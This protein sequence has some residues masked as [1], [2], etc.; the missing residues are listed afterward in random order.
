MVYV[1]MTTLSDKPSY[2]EENSALKN[3]EEQYFE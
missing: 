3:D 2:D 1:E